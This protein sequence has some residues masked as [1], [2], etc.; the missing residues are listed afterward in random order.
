MKKFNFKTFAADVLNNWNNSDSYSIRLGKNY[1]EFDFNGFMCLL[2]FYHEEENTYKICFN[3]IDEMASNSCEDVYS[4][5]ELDDI[6]EVYDLYQTLENLYELNCEED[7]EEIEDL[8]DEDWFD[9]H[10]D[11]FDF[12]EDYDDD[13]EEDDINWDADDEDLDE[14]IDNSV[15]FNIYD[16]SDRPRTCAIEDLTKVERIKVNVISGDEEVTVTYIDGSEDR[17]RSSY[18][19][20]VDYY[21]GSYDLNA[22]EFLEWIALAENFSC[23]IPYR[24]MHYYKN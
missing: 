7:E 1:I 8:E 10:D 15:E 4:S 5:L 22:V 14:E 6:K 11:Y 17:F 23:D 20:N 12:N 21:D 16:Y 3:N 2:F 13:L 24:R 18:D 19:R 9:W